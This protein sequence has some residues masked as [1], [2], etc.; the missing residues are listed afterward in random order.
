MYSLPFVSVMT[1]P[2]PEAITTS[3]SAM[4]CM[5][6]KPCQKRVGM[7][8]RLRVVTQRCT[9]RADGLGVE[10]ARQIV[11]RRER[12]EARGVPQQSHLPDGGLPGEIRP[13][14]RRAQADPIQAPALRRRGVVGRPEQDLL[15]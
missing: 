13:G 5:S 4:T 15:R 6:A 12:R 3:L 9:A 8:G 1:A 2:S 10:R 14:A 7:A 11:A